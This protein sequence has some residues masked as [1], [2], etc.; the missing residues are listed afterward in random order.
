ME[1]AS[2]AEQNCKFIFQAH[3]DCLLAHA[4]CSSWK[5]GEKRTRSIRL[6]LFRVRGCRLRLLARTTGS[7]TVVIEALKSPGE[8]L[9]HKEA[10]PFW[11]LNHERL[12]R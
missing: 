9:G 7:I 4:E 8:F 10:L 2:A 5:R 3:V 1:A 12:N 11:I 6:D